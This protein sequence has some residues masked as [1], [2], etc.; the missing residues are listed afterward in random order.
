MNN[1]L[2]TRTHRLKKTELKTETR[3]SRRRDRH[4]PPPRRRPPFVPHTTR[5]DPFFCTGTG[6]PIT[7]RSR[8]PSWRRSLAISKTRRCTAAWLRRDG[9]AAARRRERQG[10]ATHYQSPSGDKAGPADPASFSVGAD[11]P[12]E[13]H[14]QQSNHYDK[15]L[16][17]L[18]Q[19]AGTP[20]RPSEPIFAGGN[21]PS[22]GRMMT[23]GVPIDVKRQA[24]GPPRRSSRPPSR[25]SAT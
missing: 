13:G 24:G 3:P 23:G 17:T 9:G 16:R 1:Y 20:G 25:K 5:P 12:V 14:P 6:E 22:W 18:E 4:P 19:D 21:D 10:K 15:M 11:G 8:Q 2:E 7:D